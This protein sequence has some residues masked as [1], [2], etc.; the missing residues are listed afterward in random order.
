[1][2]N[3]VYFFLP[4]PV[5]PTI[6]FARE[7]EIRDGASSVL[8]F[9]RSWAQPQQKAQHIN[10]LLFKGSTL[11]LQKTYYPKVNCHCYRTK[12]I[13]PI[14]TAPQDISYAL[15]VT[16]ILNWRDIEGKVWHLIR[17]LWI[18]EFWSCGFLS[19]L[20]FFLH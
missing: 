20:A 16:Q 9:V 5:L 17:C 13:Q 18:H 10:N 12:N 2:S 14:V 6:A 1:M 15:N 7:W 19:I 8:V 3:S 4:I 11:G